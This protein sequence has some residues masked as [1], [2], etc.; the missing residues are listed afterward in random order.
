MGMLDRLKGTEPA[1]DALNATLAAAEQARTEAQARLEELSERRHRLLLDGDDRA[2]DKLDADIKAV[3][4][5]R[6]RAS[7][8]AIDAKR[9]V[10]EAE[11]CRIQERRDRIF[12]EGMEAQAAAIG[13]V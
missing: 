9:R 1:V 5:E 2:L 10:A 7:A 12:A 13:L 3:V 6:D 4:R 8:R 11:Q